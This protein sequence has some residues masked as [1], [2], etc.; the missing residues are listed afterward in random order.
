MSDHPHVYDRSFFEYLDRSSGAS[1]KSFLARVELGFPVTSVLDVG[2]GRGAW[3]EAWIEHG[4][5]D[6]FGVD[7]SYVDP[8][9]LL[10]P[11]AV[12]AHHDVSAP[13]ELGRTFDLV[14]CL[15]V[16]EHVHEE[17]SKR[18]L[19]N[20]A[21]HGS[22]VLFSAATPGQGGEHH[23]NEQPLE[24]WADRFHSLGYRCYDAVRPQLVDARGVEPW[25]RYNTLLFADDEG[26]AR[27]PEPVVAT[28]RRPGE[29]LRRFAS[30]A[31][32]AR[33]ALLRALP[34]GAINALAKVK[35]RVRR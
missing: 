7:G 17:H 18:L 34:Y 25:Y 24:Y 23:V 31:W 5:D 10:V 30:R 16:A 20:L 8:E 29:P 3:L 15:E 12:F 13:F 4:V 21:R 11:R 33:N 28:E 19:E 9:T 1:A 2:C 22:V 6:V 27:L 32:R 26:A 35:H 14:Q